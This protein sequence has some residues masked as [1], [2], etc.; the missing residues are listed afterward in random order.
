[1]HARGELAEIRHADVENAGAARGPEQAAVE[2]AGEHLGEQGDD[3]DAHGREAKP[4]VG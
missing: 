3:V 4:P 2:E 1:V